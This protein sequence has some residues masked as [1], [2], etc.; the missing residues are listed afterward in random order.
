MEADEAADRVRHAV[1]EEGSSSQ[2]R[3]RFRIRAAIV[4]AVLA[5]LLAIA[6]PIGTNLQNSIINGGLHKQ[7]IISKTRLAMIARELAGTP[8]PLF[9]RS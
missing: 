7:W 3:E 8:L 4:I 1:D 2:D 9:V 6:S 5:M